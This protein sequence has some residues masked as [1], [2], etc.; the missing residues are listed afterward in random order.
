M[1]LYFLIALL[2][3]STISHAAETVTPSSPI[4]INESLQKLIDIDGVKPL[5]EDCKSRYSTQKIEDILNCLWTEVGKKKELKKKIQTVYTEELKSKGEAS[6]NPTND[7]S[8]ASVSSNKVSLTSRETNV[9]INYEANPAVDALSK[10][11]AKKLDEVLNAEKAL[12]KDELK[13]GTILAVDHKQFIELYKSELGKTI[14]NAFTS[15]CIDTDPSKATCSSAGEKKWNCEDADYAISDDKVEREKNR[16]DNIASLATADLD[17]NSKESIKWKTCIA[18]V[19]TYCKDDS[20]ETSKRSCLIVDYVKAARKNIIIADKQIDAYKELNSKNYMNAV[21]NTK[22]ITDLKK[23][24]SDSLLELTSAD[25]KESLK[26]PTEKEAK[27]FENCYKDNVIVNMA[28]CKQYLSTNT[29]GN[30]KAIAELGMRQIAQEGVLEDQLNSSDDRVRD[31]LKEEGYSKNEIATMTDKDNIE[32]IKKQILERYRAQKTA[33]IKEMAAKIESKTSTA[34]AKIDAKDLSKIALI[35]EEMSK[36]SEDLE[37]LV[38]FNNIVA[39]YL[40][41]NDSSTKK[42]ERNTASLFAEAKS[43]K[44]DQAKVLNKQI[45]KAKLTDQKGTANSVDLNVEDI[46][47]LLKYETKEKTK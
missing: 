41:V 8:P 19:T 47:T 11:Y 7:R 2:L 33:I 36:R 40:D 38:R 42:S 26:A 39:S 15:Y 5:Y 31:Y 37:N 20:S 35:K 46:N 43:M 12:T 29:D 16:K 4:L 14:I 22:A 44:E 27:D 6:A 10:F 30:N 28:A 9:A 17:G 32:S 13:K 25:V 18:K 45:E 21:Q 1:K 34:D 23:T 3:S 24:S